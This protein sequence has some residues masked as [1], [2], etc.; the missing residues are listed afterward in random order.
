LGNIDTL[1]TAAVGGSHQPEPGF[2]FEL[3]VELVP[4]VE[5]VVELGVELVPELVLEDEP[6][7]LLL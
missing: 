1:P 7:M 6:A 5:V 2:A 4:E 3:K